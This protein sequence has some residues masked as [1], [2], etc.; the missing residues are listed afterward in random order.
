M[1]IRDSITLCLNAGAV[2]LSSILLRAGAR[3]DLPDANGTTPLESH[4]GLIRG[5]LWERARLVLLSHRKSSGG[6]AQLRGFPAGVINLIIYWMCDSVGLLG[7]TAL[8][9]ALYNGNCAQISF[10][11]SC[12][13]DPNTRLQS[14]YEPPVVQTIRCRKGSKTPLGQAL[15][16]ERFDVAT[17]LVQAGADLNDEQ[18]RS[19]P[20]GLVSYALDR[21]QLQFARLLVTHNANVHGHGPS[22]NSPLLFCASKG[23]SDMAAWLIE[24]GADVNESRSPL[25]CA[26]KRG[27]LGL[28]RILVER[29]AALHGSNHPEDSD[30]DS[31]S[32]DSSSDDSDEPWRR[33]RRDRSRDGRRDH[34]W[35]V[36]PVLPTDRSRS[37]ERMS[38]IQHTLMPS[39]ENPHETDPGAA[40]IAAAKE[41]HVEVVSFLLRHYQ[42]DVNQPVGA[43]TCLL[44][45]IEHRRAELADHL[46]S[47]L[48]ADVNKTTEQSPEGTA[49][50]AAIEHGLQDLARSMVTEH[51]ALLNAVQPLLFTSLP[52]SEGSDMSDPFHEFR[53]HGW[54][55]PLPSSTSWKVDL[56]QC[57]LEHRAD[58]NVVADDGDTPL[59]RAIHGHHVDL[60]RCLVEEHQAGLDHSDR[61]GLTALDYAT[62]NGHL[63][64]VRFLIRHGASTGPGAMVKND[65]M[66]DMMNEPVANCS[67]DDSR[68]CVE[69]AFA[70]G[71]KPN[72]SRRRH[73][74]R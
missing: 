73:G 4:G 37:R 72:R 14:E 34:R 54:G 11:I 67:L 3:A 17:C 19:N 55:N 35:R 6:F 57:L 56:A 21:G 51:G 28:T 15:A 36:T 70:P 38:P 25:A 7:Q 46:L 1:C 27:D 29:G 44:T 32:S 69:D 22:G 63:D 45:A 48:G 64:L 74:G 42:L 53:T 60:A 39:E 40:L 61:H 5:F 50:R 24:H 10:L 68:I 8:K 20:P 26:I 71:R 58:P 30:S 49:L 23:L 33:P 43:T 13:A 16:Q 52:T 59:L 41:G 47:V 18:L 66:S 12:G 9:L 65:M 2:D 31:E 62:L